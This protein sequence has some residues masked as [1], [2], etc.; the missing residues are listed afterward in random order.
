MFFG[1]LKSDRDRRQSSRFPTWRRQKD[2]DLVS[3]QGPESS[4]ASR[5]VHQVGAVSEPPKTA[6]AKEDA[7][8]EL[9]IHAR[10][11]K[12]QGASMTLLH[13]TRN[14]SVRIV[15][16]QLL[17]TGGPIRQR[18]SL[19]NVLQNVRTKL[20]RSEN[21]TDMSESCPFPQAQELA[22]K[23]VASESSESSE[24]ESAPMSPIKPVPLP[25]LDL[26][27]DFSPE[28]TRQWSSTFQSGLDD[29]ATS[30]GGTV[31]AVGSDKAAPE[32]TAE[33]LGPIATR[34]RRN[35]AHRLSRRPS[36]SRTL[37][38]QHE[39]SHQP[40]EAPS[41]ASPERTSRVPLPWIDKVLETSV[42]QRS[43]I[44]APQPIAEANPSS[45][46]ETTSD[47]STLVA[48]DQALKAYYVEKLRKMCLDSNI[49]PS[50]LPFNPRIVSRS[51]KGGS[52]ST[53]ARAS[54]TSCERSTSSRTYAESASEDCTVSSISS[55]ALSL[56]PRVGR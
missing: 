18:K 44:E 5:D 52:T 22:V 47:Y 56:S 3:K 53:S 32:S 16:N 23:A 17:V 38:D 48:S 49:D 51:Q 19:S 40:E 42:A 1:S 30:I 13:L 50:Y 24:P 25:S 41:S 14:F 55:L 8:D 37:R 26:L 35:A 9:P 45:C 27:H 43:P 39:S 2:A 15:S 12:V 33:V 21:S 31:A 29:A 4:S 54:A 46:H 34:L 28:A 11:N 36:P 10:F 20:R 7:P 6:S